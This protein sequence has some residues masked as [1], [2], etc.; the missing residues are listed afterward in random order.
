MIRS[1]YN[2]NDIN[3]TF[4]K[5]AEPIETDSKDSKN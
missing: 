4:N 1:V 3:K 5:T 2:G